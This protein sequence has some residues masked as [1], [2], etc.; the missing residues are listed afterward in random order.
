VIDH[1]LTEEDER[2]D[3]L[4]ST[5][6]LLAKRS[7]YICAYPG[8]K[9]MTVAGSEDRKSGL[10]MT[11]VAAHITAASKKGPRYDPKMSA[12]ERAGETNGIWT[13]QIHGKFID[14][15][16]SKCSVDELRRWK[17]QHEKW[18]FDR[19]ESGVEL[20]NRGVCR[21]SF[22][23]VGVFSGDFAAPFGRNNVL[24]GVNE[25]G[26]TTFCQILSAFSGGAHWK[27]FNDRFSF[28]K[29]SAS[30]A[31]IKLSHQSDHTTTAIRLSPQV[32]SGD[33]WKANNARQRVHI[34][35]ND[36]PS[37]DWP[38][39]LFRILYFENQLYHTHY[40]EPKDTFVKALR[41]LANVLGT[42]EDLVWDS[43]REE[44]FTSS[45][46]GNRFRRTGHRKVEILVPDGRTFFL[47]HE[48]L[49]FTEQ[50]MA[51]LDISFKLAYCGSKNENWIYVFD[52][53]FF[54]RLDQKRKS[55]VFK[56]LTELE[57][58][59]VQTLFCLNSTEDA[60]VLR[61]IQ[62]DK[63]VNAEHFGGLTLHSFL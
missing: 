24:V 43:L 26:K 15:N 48:G 30:R 4:S 20:F 2:D 13:C 62:A 41:Y 36:S 57:R 10:T 50:Q 14:D 11:G 55:F 35:I 40:S 12:E 63:W 16:P 25:S 52:T 6:E 51:F 60:E 18:V 23:N 29:R 42:D 19:V 56:K 45:T 9:R 33:R 34:E 3:F 39:S 47:P 44:L 38:R 61:D 46:F 28:S 53:A 17:A 22:G 58:S 32:M 7:G 8:C 54:Q 1:T 37:P 59:N 49:S 21:L 5:R 31:Y 27:Q